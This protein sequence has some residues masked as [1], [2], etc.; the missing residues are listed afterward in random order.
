MRRLLRWTFH[1]LAAASL[2]LCLATAGLWVRST[3][4]TTSYSP[5]DERRRRPAR[6][7]KTFSRGTRGPVFRPQNTDRP[8][9]NDRKH[10][11]T[12]RVP[13]EVH[14]FRAENGEFRTESDQFRTVNVQFRSEND[15]FR[16]END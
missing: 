8:P 4:C 10:A 5:F 16:T 6:I 11:E 2:L 12:R 3:G 14:Q 7:R 9:E 1:A 15:Q 13:G